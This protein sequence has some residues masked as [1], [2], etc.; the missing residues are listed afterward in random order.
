M[1]FFKKKVVLPDNILT[2]K[3]IL[4]EMEFDIYTHEYWAVKVIEEPEYAEAMGDYEWHMR[5]IN[6]YESIIY[7]L[8]KD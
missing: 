8:R 2:V 4:E 7:H 6:V 1:C 5:W 3:K